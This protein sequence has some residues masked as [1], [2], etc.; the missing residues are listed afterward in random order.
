MEKK[1]KIT[2][3]LL[4]LA[5][6][7]VLG[8]VI[9]FGVHFYKKLTTEVTSVYHAIP[10]NS[11]ALVEVDK[12][13]VFWGKMKN[14]LIYHE[15]NDIQ[16]IREYTHRIDFLDSLLNK[17]EAFRAWVEK[18][19]LVLS[20]H[21]RGSDRFSLLGLLQLSTTR[22]A[23]EVVGLIK[24]HATVVSIGEHPYPQYK[25]TINDSNVFYFSVPEGILMASY[26]AA[27]LSQSVEFLKS[28][29]HILTDAEFRSVY[30]VKGNNEDAHIFFNHKGFHRFLASYAAPDQVGAI[31]NWSGFAGWSELDLNLTPRGLWFS[32]YTS[33]NDSSRNFLSVF[34]N[35]KADEIRL[36][37]VVSSRTAAIQYFGLDDFASFY[38][39]YQSFRV[40]QP[41][42]EKYTS[43][44]KDE[45]DLDIEDYFI[46]WID[47]EFARVTA[48]SAGEK[49]YHY[50]VFS[51][52]DAREAR[53]SLRKISDAINTKKKNTLDTLTYKGYPI[54]Q[55]ND[56]YLLEM[57]FGNMFA[58]F[59]NPYYTV[60]DDFV[61]FAQSHNAIKT[62]ITEYTLENTL[63]ANKQYKS[64]LNNM[65][66]QAN[67][68]YYYNL[69]YALEYFLDHVSP[70]M[71]AFMQDDMNEIKNIPLGGFQYRYQDE[72]IY[73]NFYLGADTTNYQQ[74]LVSGWKT[75]LDAEI[76]RK[77]QFVID[78]TNDQKKIVVFDRL[79]QM[80]LINL[81]GQIEWKIQLKEL[82]AGELELVDIYNN[83]KYQY[84]FSTPSYIYCVALDG[85]FVDGYP[86][87][88]ASSNTNA[89][90]V[91]DYKQNSS[92]RYLVAGEDQTIYNYNKEGKP[93]VGWQFPQV[94]HLVTTKVQRLLIENKDFIIIADTAGNVRFLNRRGEERIVPQPAF[95]NDPATPFYPAQIRDNAGMITTD[96]DG[97][98]IF[99]DKEGQ[100]EKIV[101]NE[102][103]VGYSFAFTDF[104]GDG[105]KDFL[106]LSNRYFYAYDQNWEIISTYELA[107]DMQPGIQA[108]TLNGSNML[109]AR[110]ADH[111][112]VHLL[113]DDAR[114]LNETPVSMFPVISYVNPT[115]NKRNIVLSDGKRLE[116]ILLNE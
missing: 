26:D 32:G 58:Q 66:G 45:Y 16:K 67:V 79:K 91:F 65:A 49:Y 76:A 74:S 40:D 34:H 83:D 80:Y 55:I 2:Y 102:F 54:G 12:P 21:Y 41:K 7:V 98:V 22:Q 68:Y 64:F 87:R 47:N 39:K 100:V 31:Q 75:A 84:L 5:A 73:T 15:L 44:F 17:N 104:N 9:F 110:T 85:N 11:Y 96:K 28:G 93:V 25:A 52:R 114:L 50:A 3:S 103:D 14:Q 33:L 4:G 6:V 19:K 101:L 8:V 105:A 116:S 63:Q 81:N 82:P 38:Q 46:S 106:Y 71:K 89:V 107:Y 97:R 88:T 56:P 48:K 94:D 111:R 20:L 24:E 113:M 53:Q 23:D 43:N 112:L 10:G 60:I 61:F 70:S 13:S 99:I 35:Q 51:S 27:L 69:Q 108:L 109:L 30:Q 92:Y 78:H 36:S 90:A 86:F 57:F 29:R 95:T 77:P 18:G 1:K 59:R 37:S 115:E 42:L 62:A 72:K